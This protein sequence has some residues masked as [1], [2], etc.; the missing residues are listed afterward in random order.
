MIDVCLFVGLFYSCPLKIPVKMAGT[1]YTLNHQIPIKANRLDRNHYNLYFR[2]QG[3]HVVPAHIKTHL[4]HLKNLRIADVGTGTDIFLRSLAEELLSTAHLDGF[5]P[6][7][8]KFPNSETLPSNV[9]LHQ[10]DALVPFP[11]A[12]LGSYDLVHLRLQFF[13]WDKDGWPHVVRNW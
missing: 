1:L 2:L 7:A 5:D 12:L 11:N 4:N 10:G 6:D 9:K 13:S 8:T 3:D